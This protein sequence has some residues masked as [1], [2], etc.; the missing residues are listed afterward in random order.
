MTC[1]ISLKW[2]HPL[3]TA[4]LTSHANMDTGSKVM[5]FIVTTTN[6]K[7]ARASADV[8]GTQVGN[9]GMRTAKALLQTRNI[10]NTK[11]ERINMDWPTA[12]APVKGRRN[13]GRNCR[14]KNRDADYK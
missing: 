4:H 10:S 5:R 11:I 8:L 14:S 3:K 6:G 7:K 12:D 1:S 13:D 9:Q 2:L